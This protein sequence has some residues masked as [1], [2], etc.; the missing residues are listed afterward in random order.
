MVHHREFEDALTSNMYNNKIF[1][2][3]I[4]Q[5]SNYVISVR[6]KPALNRYLFC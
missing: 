1:E 3:G 6:H 4:V 5:N 2:L